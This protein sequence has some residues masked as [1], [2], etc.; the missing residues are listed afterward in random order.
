MDQSAEAEWD[1]IPPSQV[2]NLI[3]QSINYITASDLLPNMIPA[4]M[5]PSASICR[6]LRLLVGAELKVSENYWQFHAYFCLQLKAAANSCDAPEER[7][8]WRRAAD[9]EAKGRTQ[10][11]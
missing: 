3:K 7:M 5:I 9:G 2:L 8:R 6:R 4:L 1:L 11:Q 10:V